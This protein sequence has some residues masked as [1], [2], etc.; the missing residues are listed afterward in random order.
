MPTRCRGKGNKGKAGAS[1]SNAPRDLVLARSGAYKL[2]L[3]DCPNDI[4]T[5][6]VT[7]YYRQQLGKDAVERV[8]WFFNPCGTFIGSGVLVFET[9][10]ART[11]A[12]LLPGPLASGRQ[13]T[14]EGHKTSGSEDKDTELYLWEL[15]PSTVVSDLRKCYTST[16]L[17]RIKFKMTADYS[18]SVGVA[19]V[20]F[21]SPEAAMAALKMGPPEIRGSK[22]R[23][24]FSGYQGDKEVC[25]QGSQRLTDDVV[26]K[27]YE[28]FGADGILSIHWLHDPKDGQFLGR[29][30]VCFK[31]AAMAS[32]ALAWGGFMLGDEPIGV[33]KTDKKF[34]VVE[35]GRTTNDGWRTTEGW[36]SSD[37]E[38]SPPASS[39][40]T[41]SETFSLGSTLFSPTCATPSS[42]C[43]SDT[44]SV[45][46][47]FPT[48]ARQCPPP[49]PPLKPTP[50]Q[51]TSPSSGTPS[52]P[53]P[54]YITHDSWRTMEG[55][56]SMTGRANHR[57]LH[58]L[59]LN[60]GAHLTP[61][62][63]R[64]VHRL[65]RE[66]PKHGRLTTHGEQ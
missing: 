2:L 15:P 22:C 48:C 21:E 31:T 1:P 27:Q 3:L 49:S 29:G 11:E 26:R 56:L 45:D 62:H 39:R 47:T 37:S 24:K 40:R 33:L 52:T 64:G 38:T 20:G 8:K 25:V 53:P 4:T 60:L 35:K 61:F 42:R 17:K 19:F 12:A 41:S 28:T 16:G 57:P 55:W 5:D 50:T 65:E 32:Q 51:A 18:S 14:V 36:A 54:Q 6:D 59:P 66:A 10:A 23:V 30:F 13:V 43:A 9:E 34:S 44:D 58:H 7:S 63:R 46:G